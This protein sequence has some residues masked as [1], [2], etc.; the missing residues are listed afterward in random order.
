M[1]DPAE[2][3]PGLHT[4]CVAAATPAGY[5]GRVCRQRAR[6]LA[7]QTATVAEQTALLDLANNAI[8]VWNLRGGAIRYWSHGAE[9]LACARFLAVQ[10]RAGTRQS[11]QTANFGVQ[12]DR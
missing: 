2:W 1:N 12:V 4:A 5:F 10:D 3:L 8:L 11:P 7:E 9:E 6:R